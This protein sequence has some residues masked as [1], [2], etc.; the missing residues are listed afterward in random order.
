MFYRYP[1]IDI[2]KKEHII[3]VKFLKSKSS[4][5]KEGSVN[6]NNLIR[7]LIDWFMHHT[8]KE[9]RKIARYILD[10]GNE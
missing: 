3:L 5:L 2:Q 9:D 10:K 8:Q 7:F 1:D 4:G 6:G